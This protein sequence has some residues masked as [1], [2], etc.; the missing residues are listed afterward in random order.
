[1]L[2]RILLLIALS[3]S[4]GLA[5]AQDAVVQGQVFDSDGEIAMYAE[6]L[7]KQETQVVMLQSQTKAGSLRFKVSSRGAM[8]LKFIMETPCHYM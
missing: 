8:I 2:P 4:F 5:T 7:I 1:M 3:F 6:V